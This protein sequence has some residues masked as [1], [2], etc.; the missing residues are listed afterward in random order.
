MRP[1][2]ETLMR[3]AGLLHSLLVGCVALAQSPLP[4]LAGQ[5]LQRAIEILQ[6]QGLTVFY[7]S[8]LVGPDMRVFR[9]PDAGELELALTEI[10]APHGLMAAPGPRGSLLIVRDPESTPTPASEVATAGSDPAP[11][12]SPGLEEIVV[13]ASRY[14][15]VR[16]IGTSQTS[17]T[18]SDIE[19]LP[20]VGEDALRALQRLPG[21]AANGFSARSSVRGG[22]LDETLVRLDKLRL[23]NPYHLKSFQSVFSTVDPRIVDTM[24]VYTGGFPAPF[25]DRMSGVID[26]ET[27]AAPEERFH[28]L[29]MSFFNASA[30]TSG[31]FAEGRGEWLASARRSNLDLLYNAFSSLPERPRYLDAFAKLGYQLNEKLRLTGNLL[32]VADDITL[33]DDIDLEE[34]ATADDLDRYVWLRLDHS[35]R[36]DL[37]G[38]TL[39]SRAQL[40]SRRTGSTDKPGISRGRLSDS[41]DF[42]IDSVQSD[43]TWRPDKAWLVHFGGVARYS[44]GNYS[45]FDEAEFD[46][47][48]AV[49]G[50][51]TT[52]NRSRTVQLAPE[53]DQF[54]LFGSVRRELGPRATVDLGLR[55]DQQTLDPE[56]SDSL[57]PRI[58]LRYRV[59]KRSFIKASWGRFYQ[60]QTI[61]ELQVQDGVD[62]FFAPQRADHSVIGFEHATAE[63][64]QLRVEVYEKR[65]RVLRPR[66]ENL[67]NSLTLLPELKPDRIAIAPDAAYARGA[68]L[69]LSQRSDSALSWWLG[70]S[71]SKVVDRIDTTEVFRA[72]DQT[73]AFTGGLNVDTAKWN[74]GFA[75]IYRSGWPT[76]AVDLDLS[77]ATP[78]VN[79][80]ARNTERVDFFRSFDFRLTRKF[81]LESGAVS[82]FVEI[83][84][85][86]GRNN[87]CCTEYEINAEQG[88]GLDLELSRLNYLPFVPSIGFVWQF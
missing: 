3:K 80:A 58:G 15:L 45:Y 59:G 46:L 39:I 70:Y 8:D 72:W 65:M 42:S 44:K 76:S 38:S 12:A 52:T 34:Q 49:P 25:G 4:P 85:V 55:W 26:V 30:L 16:Q 86:F 19:Y 10:L 62:T 84:N 81:A 50:A 28:E 78:M 77:G 41:R 20:D 82:A 6:A 73:H 69:L 43:W 24:N 57:A 35:L 60:S 74:I 51:S 36:D 27:L 56:H 83:N 67:L 33:S 63:G 66:F 22:D 1:C 31:A 7:S 18:G 11:A 23:Y 54:A 29:A 9:E 71:R 17:L 2:C 32:Y 48:F 47:L 21:A 53:G 79:V 68:E 13:A 5:S 37:T 61:N 64:L 75:V 40:D 87:P 14:E 88:L